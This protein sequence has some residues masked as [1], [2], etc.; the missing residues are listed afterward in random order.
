MGLG[1]AVTEDGLSAGVYHHALGTLYCRPFPACGDGWGIGER[2]GRT[3]GKDGQT[4][5][6]ALFSVRRT[7]VLAS[8][9]VHRPGYRP[10]PAVP[11]DRSWTIQGSGMPRSL[12]IFRARLSLISVCRGTELCALSAGLCHHEW[13]P[14]SRKS[15][16]R[17][18]SCGA[19][20][21]AASNAD[22]QLAIAVSCG[23]PGTLSVH[24][25]SFCQRDTQGLQKSFERP[26]L[27]IDAR[28]FFNPANV[29]LAILLNY[30]CVLLLH[31]GC[32]A[33]D[34][35]SGGGYDSFGSRVP[36]PS[37]N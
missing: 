7:A 9:A 5:T 36:V 29:P 8:R 33:T 19:A 26:F 25:Q 24:V 14:P 34:C 32:R 18:V 17:V 23:F 21:H 15:N 3:A 35:Q 16:S 13:L 4:E 37:R 20:N 22:A 30:G 31:V 6:A 11:R 2:S 27:A 10:A 12:Q 1:G 28:H